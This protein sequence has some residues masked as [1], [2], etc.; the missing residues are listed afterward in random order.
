MWAEYGGWIEPGEHSG[1]QLRRRGV[2]LTDEVGGVLQS[3]GK[4]ERG[5]ATECL[6]STVSFIP[7]QH[8]FCSTENLFNPAAAQ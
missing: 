6:I 4:E 5:C 7:G 2:L 3:Y 1:K 8:L